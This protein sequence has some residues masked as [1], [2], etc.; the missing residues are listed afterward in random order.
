MKTM[1]ANF[2]E[3][4]VAPEFMSDPYPVLRQLREQ[5]P[6]YW[7]DSIGGWLLT[8]YDDVL[9]SFKNTALFSN[10]NRLGKTVQYLPPEKQ[11]HYKDVVDHYA[12]KGLIH[13]DP[14][15]TPGCAL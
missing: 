4:L 13:S 11:A 10:E 5:D 1:N 9:V 6:V 15:I 12:V 14:R 8:R 2:E 7:S 3:L